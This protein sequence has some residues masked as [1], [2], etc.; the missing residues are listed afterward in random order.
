[1]GGHR[2]I[3]GV[4][5]IRCSPTDAF[6]MTPS[7]DPRPASRYQ[8]VTVSSYRDRLRTTGAVAEPVRAAGP[9]VRLL[10]HMP[11]LLVPLTLGA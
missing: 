3:E 6:A 11:A 9:R 1:M 2:C 7:T 10:R 8:A 4:I 5:E